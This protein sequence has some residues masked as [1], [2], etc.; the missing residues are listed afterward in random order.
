MMIGILAEYFNNEGSTKVAAVIPNEVLAAIQ[1]EKYAPW[2]SRCHD[3]LWK[4]KKDIQYCTYEDF[5]TGRIPKDTILL[6]DEI[7]SLFFSEKPKI[8][9]GKVLSVIHLLN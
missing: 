1:Q 6:V 7:D 4:N 3:D 8:R 9:G 5:A 2:A